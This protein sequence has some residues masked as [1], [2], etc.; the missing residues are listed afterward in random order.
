[1]SVSYKAVKEQ[2]DEYTIRVRNTGEVV[3][4]C[5]GCN[6]QRIIDKLDSDDWYREQESKNEASN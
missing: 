1:M 4:W 2:G 5:R 3:R 6:V